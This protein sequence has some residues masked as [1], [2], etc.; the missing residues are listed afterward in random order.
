MSM[1]DTPYVDFNNLT[2]MNVGYE[3][4]KSSYYVN[5]QINRTDKPS[6]YINLTES[7]MGTYAALQHTDLSNNNY[8]QLKHNS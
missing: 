4:P 2:C 5:Q 1:H 7:T 8:E 6:S 3:V